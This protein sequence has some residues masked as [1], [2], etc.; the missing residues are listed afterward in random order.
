MVKKE[1]AELYLEELPLPGMGRPS[2]T[3]SEA[4][5]A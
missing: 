5:Y 4:K 3:T 1:A 2:L